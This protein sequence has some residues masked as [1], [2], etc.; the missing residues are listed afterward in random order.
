MKK[1]LLY[2]IIILTIFLM[3]TISTAQP[4]QGYEF[5]V[6]K[7]AKG[8][9]T[10]GQVMVYDEDEWEEHLGEDASKPDDYFGG[11][12]DIIGAK[13]KTKVLGW[14]KDDRSID[15]FADF[16]L[17]AEVEV[18]DTPEITD[19]NSVFDYIH[20][21]ITSLTAFP[22]DSPVLF[23]MLLCVNQ[24]NKQPAGTAGNWT[25]SN[26]SDAFVKANTYS[27]TTDY[28]N[29][30]YPKKLDGIILERDF[31]EYT[32]EKFDEKPD[33]EED[34]VPFLADPYDWYDTYKRLRDVKNELLNKI[35]PLVD[36]MIALNTSFNQ[37]N[38]TNWTA[39]NNTVLV[40]LNLLK[41]VPPKP[42][43]ANPGLEN[44]PWMLLEAALKSDGT[45]FLQNGTSGL[46][47]INDLV[48]G[49]IPGKF[50]FLYNLLLEGLP[51]YKPTDHFLGKI[52]DYFDIDDEDIEMGIP[53]LDPSI[54]VRGGVELEGS[55]IT[56]KFEYI[57]DTVDPADPDEELKDWE[58]TFTY[59]DTGSQE[60]VIFKDD[61][62]EEFY[63]S[64]GL[65]MDYF[66][67]P[68]VRNI[69]IAAGISAAVAILGVIYIIMRKRRK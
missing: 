50:G 61:D 3:S 51:I 6:P 11:D 47:A 60:S 48:A 4:V 12:A 14:E 65:P 16:V 31:W 34:E 7:E 20:S 69:A 28:V 25:F 38:P 9:E 53:G 10:E 40:L 66:Q 58:V 15:F 56:L 30:K 52:V 21:G 22:G 57:D 67:I 68:L 41:I 13:S 18:E 36:S 5:G 27:I 42:G 59:G 2:G 62:G 63:R 49:S 46:L 23:G 24:F 44:L 33:K 55:A 45:N 17:E 64:E 29:Q 32:D 54:Q 26:C 1:K 8:I 43:E 19:F 39:L 35:E 37:L